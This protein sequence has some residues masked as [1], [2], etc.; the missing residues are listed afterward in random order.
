MIDRQMDGWMDGWTD[1]WVE[2]EKQMF[3]ELGQTERGGEQKIDRWVDG[4][5][6]Q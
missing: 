5:M 6:D 3:R 1:G 2:R 4:Q